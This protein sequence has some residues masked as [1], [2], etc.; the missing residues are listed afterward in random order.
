MESKSGYEAW[1]NVEDFFKFEQKIKHLNIEF[2]EQPFFAKDFHLY[3][4]CKNKTHFPMM[5]DE[6]CTSDVDIQKLSHGFHM[7]NIKLM[8]T[9]GP[10]LAI[11]QLNEARALGMKTMIGCMIETGLG[12]SQ[13]KY[14]AS[15]CDYFDLDG[16]LLLQED[17]YKTL[18]IN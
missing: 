14:L 17:P 5:A 10:L 1:T 2:I 12:I 3:K 7:L 8:K 6:S 18:D 13:A 9:G 15:L 11:K 16:N 4:D